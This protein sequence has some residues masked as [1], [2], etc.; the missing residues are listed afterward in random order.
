MR[1]ATSEPT[2]AERLSPE[3]TTAFPGAS[4]A[5]EGA[6][7]AIE[8][9]LMIVGLAALA[10]DDRIPRSTLFRMAELLCEAR[11]EGRA[12]EVLAAAHE[13]ADAL[14][15]WECPQCEETNPGTFGMCWNCS[16]GQQPSGELSPES[17]VVLGI[18]STLQ[19]KSI[20]EAEEG[21]PFRDEN[22]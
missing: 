20:E 5:S 16:Q 22:H 19:L 15:E 14:T 18:E 7:R 9:V 12:E 1:E 2:N 21:G 17:E 13:E 3:G 4:A 8:D 6:V 10:S 11:R